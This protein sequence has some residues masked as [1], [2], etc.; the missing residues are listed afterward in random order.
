M[1]TLEGDYAH[2]RIPETTRENLSCP[3]PPR[4]AI[5]GMVAAM[6]GKPRNSYWITNDPIRNLK[7]AVE[8]LNPLKRTFL[9]I[10]YIRVKETVSLDRSTKV[11]IP[12]DPFGAG[13]IGLND[14]DFQNQREFPK[15]SRGMN[16]PFKMNIMKDVKYRV[17]LSSDDDSLMQEL[18]QRLTK[19]K[20]VFPPYLGHANLLAHWEFEGIHDATPIA[21]GKPIQCNTVAPL[22]AVRLETLPYDLAGTPVLYNLPMAMKAADETK[23]PSI[24]NLIVERVE[25][26]FLVQP[27]DQFMAVFK[28]D[29]AFRVKDKSIVFL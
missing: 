13:L 1:A 20:F 18:Q 27:S 25:S 10:N 12:E 21:A 16:A 28:E 3:F 7:V 6:M 23:P 29:R 8:I 24:W 2:F 17:Y 4:T 15:Y 11:Y 26:V 9:K 5:L 19:R 22:S 14:E